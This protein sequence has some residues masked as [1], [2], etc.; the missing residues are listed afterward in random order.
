MDAQFDSQGKPVPL[1]FQK[2]VSEFAR[3]T[4][5]D[6]ESLFQGHALEHEGTHFWFRHFGDDDANGLTIQMDI[7]EA[8]PDE[9]SVVAMTHPFLQ[10][11]LSMPPAVF[12]Y[13][14]YL[15]ELNRLVHCTRI[16]LDEVADGPGAIVQAIQVRSM[17]LAG[18]RT[19]A[20]KTLSSIQGAAS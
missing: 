8:P 5:L 1:L 19:E 10:S 2:T 4:G 20:A 12:G 18:G 9:Q 14:A 16:A 3:Q 11:H 6:A 7:G 13:Y 17:L 15:P